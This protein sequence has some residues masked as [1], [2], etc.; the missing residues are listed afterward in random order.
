[1]TASASLASAPLADAD[2]IDDW[3]RP[4][5]R[6]LL[7]VVLTFAGF[8]GWAATAPLDSAVSASGRIVPESERKAIQHL[9]GG[10][11]AAIRVTEGD[12]VKDGDVL[13]EID[14]S[15]ARAA[16]DGQKNALFS[17]LGEEARL[18]ALAEGRDRLVFPDELA[19]A[20]AIGERVIADQ[21]RA[22]D[23][24]RSTNRNEAAIIDRRIGETTTAVESTRAQNR[25][26]IAQIASVEEEIAR[27]RPAVDRGSVSR[28]RLT[29]LER[30]RTDLTGRRDATAA[31]IERAV[32]TIAAL[33]VQ[34][35]QLAQ[36]AAEE[37]ATRLAELRSRIADLRDKLR[38]ATEIVG[39]TA[40]RAPR[41]GRVVGSRTHTV[42]AVV[43]PGETLMEIVPEDDTLVA[44]LRVSPLDVT[45]LWPGLD[46]EVR[47]PSIRGRNTPTAYGRV[48]MIAP[49]V[50][51][52]EAT[53]Q[54]YYAAKVSIETGG[55]PEEL[56]T[57]LRAGMPVDAMIRTGERTAL[58]YAFQPLMRAL[59]TGMREY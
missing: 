48:E 51:F 53:H 32:F 26:A 16:A 50:V 39:R 7:V 4:L 19:A 28:A 20:G 5:R 33:E 54:P 2:R 44:T 8:G 58:A 3:R 17:A 55:V 12:R 27:L 11:V 37:A 21:R 36:R 40:I 25:A 6:G 30:E 45:H 10:I 42:G 43:R 23:E 34:K 13:V 14:S 49:D 59:R 18:S 1:V 47:F 15:Q 24:V 22:F 56:R 41:A 52:E 29:A 31:E 9:E 57:Q 38:I 35:S 46:A